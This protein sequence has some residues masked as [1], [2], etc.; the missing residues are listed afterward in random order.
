ME[1]L[2]NKHHMQGFLILTES[3]LKSWIIKYGRQESV[4]VMLH[5]YIVSSSFGSLYTFCA[6]ILNDSLGFLCWSLK[7]RKSWKVYSSIV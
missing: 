3:K 4:A 2:E 7:L 5:N 6:D 1:F